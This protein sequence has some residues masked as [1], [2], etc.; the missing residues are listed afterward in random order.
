MLRFG[1][2]GHRDFFIRFDP[3][4]RTAYIKVAQGRVAATKEQ[5]PGVFV[6]LGSSGQLLGIEILDPKRIQVSL[7][8][9]L[10][11]QF[12]VPDLATL[13]PRGIPG[14]FAAA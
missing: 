9:R 6:D 12:K 7:I 10:A 13:N 11:K 3:A 4:S 2:E 8:H 14:I 1:L 5:A